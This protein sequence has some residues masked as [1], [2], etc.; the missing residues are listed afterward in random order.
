MLGRAA[1]VDVTDASTVVYATDNRNDRPGIVA[2]RADDRWGVWYNRLNVQGTW[3]AWK[4]SLRLDN[5]WF[6]ASPSATGIALDL[7][8]EHA[9]TDPTGS[10]SEYFRRELL[11][12]GVEL[13]NRYI[14]WLYPAKYSV[15]YETKLT[16]IAVGDFY[17]QLGRGLVLAVRKIDELASDVTVRGA[18]IT[19]RI[20][21]G[22]EVRLELTG[23]GGFMNPL[24]LDESSGRYVGVATSRTLGWAAVTEA[25][26]PRAV[27]TD[28]VPDRAP[29]YAPDSVVAGQAQLGSRIVK[30]GTQASLLERQGPLNQDVIRTADKILTASQSVHFPSIAESGSFYVEAAGQRLQHSDSPTDDLDG[31]AVY[32]ATTATVRPV[33][34]LVETKQYRRFFPLSANVDLTRAREFSL[35]QYSIP[36]NTLAFYSDAEVEG[37]NTCVTGGRAKGDVLLGPHASVYVWLGRYA[38][39]AESVANARCDTADENLNL[40][41]DYA[42]GFEL[43]DDEDRTRAEVTLGARDDRTVVPARLDGESTRTFYRE[44]YVRYDYVQWLGGDFSL[45]NQGWHRKRYR[46]FSGW[47]DPSFEGY[48][49]VAVHWSPKLSV[50]VSFEYDTN[51]QVAPTYVNG[52]VQLRPTSDSS[53]GLFVGQR[54]GMMRCVSGVCRVF[55]PFE[56]AR[57]EA[58]VRF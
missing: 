16:E 22:D 46:P 29:T 43:T 47:T 27:S 36:P 45:Q 2:T 15:S 21:L 18:R 58:T 48:H 53:I 32:T 1:Q 42:S 33:S 38:T 23:L 44:G 35:V 20:P 30:V 28:F 54:R 52:L 13:S 24:R 12:S 17:A 51:P 4:V 14:N 19:E 11:E 34:L 50:A 8:R 25:G 40:A 6:Y 55:P 5:A 7:W 41:W 31:Y 26:M 9:T 3:Q 39:W 10:G 56:G 49:T 57:L 37:F